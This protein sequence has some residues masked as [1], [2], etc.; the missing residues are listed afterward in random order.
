MTISFIIVSSANDYIS[1]KFMGEFD[2]G[3]QR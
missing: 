1:Y 3:K 2:E